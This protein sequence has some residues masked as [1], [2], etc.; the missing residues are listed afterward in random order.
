[1][2]S[3]YLKIFHVNILRHVIG[4]HNSNVYS[5]IVT[6]D[7]HHCLSNLLKYF[8]DLPFCKK[9]KHMVI[10]VTEP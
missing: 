5:N 10:N 8:L 3:L 4:I 2:Q 9:K 6:D 1:M 7:C